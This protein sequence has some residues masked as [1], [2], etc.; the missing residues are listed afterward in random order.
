M[1]TP[2]RLASRLLCEVVRHSSSDSRD[3]ANAMLRELDFIESDWAALLW[4]LGS[5]AAIF[6]HSARAL[7]A[8]FG[9]RDHQKEAPMMNNIGKRAGGFAVGI[10]IG[11]VFI[12]AGVSLVHLLLHSV[13]AVHSRPMPWF[14]AA[15]AISEAIFFYAVAR[16]WS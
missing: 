8:K 5:T 2:R 15:A 14:L 11:A 7:A 13:P 16:Q 10:A 3:W 9:R 4:A 12:V 6:R 1:S